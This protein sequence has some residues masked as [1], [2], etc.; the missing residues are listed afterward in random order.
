[1]TS[2]AL[3][4]GVLLPELLA[5]GGDRGNVLVLAHRLRARGHT[6]E[7]VEA[8]L[9][10]AVPESL[11]L[12]LLGGAE[13]RAQL[14]A[15]EH[16]RRDPGLARA[17][18]RGIPVLAAGGGISVLG[19][20][21]TTAEGRTADGPGL[22]DLDTVYTAERGTGETV[23]DPAPATGLRAP[24]SGFANRTGVITLGGA[25]RPLGRVT[26]GVGNDPRRDAADHGGEGAVQGP[27]VATGLQGP[28]LARNPELADLVLAAALGVR[29]AD[30]QP[31]PMPSVQRLRTERLRA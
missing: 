17:V 19:H 4:I 10:T 9:D 28:V 15:A 31:L 2:S 22:L 18:E 21:L 25:A 11:D 13:D 5:V 14:P 6:V 1:M 26:R 20:R 16:L 12:Y 30:L 24:L 23:V 7:L 8:G 3:R 29:A 27:I